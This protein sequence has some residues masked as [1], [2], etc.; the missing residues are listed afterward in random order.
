MVNSEV[1]HSILFKIRII[2]LLLSQKNMNTK[3]LTVNT[4]VC[5]TFFVKSNFTKIICHII[6]TMTMLS[7]FFQNVISNSLIVVSF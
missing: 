1:H 2:K 5:T 3:C 4:A 7:A 6:I